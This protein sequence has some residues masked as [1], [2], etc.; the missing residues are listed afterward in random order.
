MKI[1]TRILLLLFFAVFFIS[2]EDEGYADYDPGDTMVQELSGDWYVRLLLDGEDVY[3]IGY[4]LLSTYNTADDNGEEMWVDDHELWPM[5]VTTP[6]NV[7]GKT[8]S[9]SDLGNEYS[10]EDNDE[11]IISPVVD[12]IDGGVLENATTSPGGTTTDSIYMN[13]EFSDDPGTTYTIAGY[14]RT[15]FFEDEH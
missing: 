14:A 1:F 12:I 8:F 15:G 2:C 10:Y 11:N 9:G 4:Y 3:G 6:V 5:K 7:G 13:V